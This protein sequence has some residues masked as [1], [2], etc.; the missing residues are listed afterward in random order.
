MGGVLNISKRILEEIN[1][2]TGF[3]EDLIEKVL[4]LEGLLQDIFRHPFLKNRLLLKG[5]TALNFCYLNRSRLSVDIDLNYIGNVELGIMRQER[6][7]MDE[8]FIRIVKDKGY[9][10]LKEPGN[11]HAGGK[12][13]LGYKNIWGDNKN[14]EFDINYL[15]RVPIGTPEKKF[16]KAFDDSGQFEIA[17]VSK[18]EL[19]AG[20]FVAALDRVTA[21]DVYDL[22]NIVDYSQNYDMQLFRKTVILFGASK[23][24]DLRE[25][26][27]DRLWNVSDAEIEASLYPLLPLDKRIDKKDILNKI[28][29]FVKD[30]LR[31]T[32]SEK[33]FLDRYLD[34]ADY[35][36]EIL[37]HGYPDLI[38]LLKKHPALLW[39]RLNIE[40]FLNRSKN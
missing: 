32:S 3:N 20:K 5:G 37:F 24:E 27:L 11:E 25:F 21:R 9:S 2:S 13:R 40:E 38:P 34:Y 19:F 35:R 36:P 10:L 26:R 8:A 16:F 1:N 39:K 28:D 22:A 18:E 7:K 30:L 15:F 12:W 29:P 31:F 4:R 17:I 33:E 23:R 6:P 14:L